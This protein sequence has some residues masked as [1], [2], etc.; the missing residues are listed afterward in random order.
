LASNAAYQYSATRL[1]PVTASLIML[2][3]VLF[4][5][6]SSVAMGV[7]EITLRLTLGGALIV[8][9]A[10]LAAWGDRPAVVVAGGFASAN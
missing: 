4:A 3:E 1:S 9:A 8:A 10:A 5:S 6:L 7:S 2:T